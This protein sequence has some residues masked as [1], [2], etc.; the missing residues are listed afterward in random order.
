M[1]DFF[2]KHEITIVLVAIIVLCVGKIISD[3]MTEKSVTYEPFTSY[4]QQV[5]SDVSYSYSK[6][7]GY[8]ESI[9]IQSILTDS[10]GELNESIGE[11]N[12]IDEAFTKLDEAAG[13]SG[14]L[15]IPAGAS[16]I[17]F[18]DMDLFCWKKEY[19]IFF[20]LIPK[21]DTEGIIVSGNSALEGKIE[22]G[23]GMLAGI[24]AYQS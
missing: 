6:S 2:K 1:G 17:S 7:T 12:N 24:T 8:S 13:K 11:I 22:I 3:K 23:T 4:G 14:A 15:T 18:G 20:D 19:K 9:S 21:S 16:D 10:A 5:Q